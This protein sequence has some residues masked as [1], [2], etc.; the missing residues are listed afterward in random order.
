MSLKINTAIFRAYD[1]RGI[2]DED[3]T[4]DVVEAIG[5]A[6]GTYLQRIQ[7][8]KTTVAVGRD[9]RLG[10]EK[11]QKALMQGLLSTGADVMD[12][13]LS[14]SPKLYF[15]TAYLELSGGV[16]ITGSHNPI[17]YNG[18]KMIRKG[19][20]PVAEDEIQNLR[21]MIENEDF[22]KGEGALSKREIKREYFDF[23]KK[24]INVQRRMKVVVDTGNGVAGL[25]A[26]EFLTELGCEIIG[27]YTEL[28]GTF[29]H[30]LPDPEMAEYVV[31]LI[32]EVK[33]QHADL[34][35]AFDGDGDRLGMVD[36]NGKRYEAD[37]LL[38][39][40][41]RDFL[42]RNP[43]EKIV[44]DV[45]CSQNV[46]DDIKAHGG[47]PVIWRTGH[48][49]IKKKMREDGILLGGEVSGHMFFGGKFY[50]F[51]D[52][53]LA[54]AYLLEI[55]SKSDKKLSEH[56]EGMELMPSTP[57][58]KLPCPDDKKFGVVDKISDYF[59]KLYPD[60]L[61]IDG[62]RIDFPNGWAL[63]RPSNTNPYLTLRMQGKS[64]AA[65][66]EIQSIVVRKLK[67]YPSITIP[68]KLY[69]GM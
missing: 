68:E 44:V 7:E 43:G 38:M 52:A 62:I 60:S 46:I 61:T 23:L 58:I 54:A 8:G 17:G 31:D 24:D 16:N 9:N 18:F 39:L 11:L 40:L 51:D 64:E 41:A 69:I 49:I 19:P 6:F 66:K 12:I 36:E 42:K 1:I 27:L 22:I 50:G 34:G 3:L 10:S 48:S 37:L 32:N 21:Q 15:T 47:K 45:K 4:F 26:P 67:E 29:P 59:H 53:M 14:T 28:D 5:K 63:I 2:E 30:H 56:F 35:I 33:K 13:G 57:E 65:L 55:L 20:Y 25:F